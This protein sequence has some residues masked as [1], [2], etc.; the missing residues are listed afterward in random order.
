MALHAIR[1]V[2]LFSIVAYFALISNVSQMSFRTFFVFWDNVRIRNSVMIVF[3]VILIV[4]MIRYIE[5]ISLN[6]YFDFDQN[7][8]KEEYDGGVSLRNFPTKAA[9]FL[10]YNKIKGRFFNDFNSGAYLLG[11]A[12][13][14]IQV[15]I[16]GR[17]ELYGSRFFEDYKRIGEGDVQLFSQLQHLS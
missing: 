6:G 8:R 16:D 7:E 10:E 3:H 14:N 17:T 1:N 4:G 11:R 15:F 12:Y 9:D 5:N 13:P 2:A